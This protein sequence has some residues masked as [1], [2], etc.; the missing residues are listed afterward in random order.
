MWVTLIN[1]FTGVSQYMSE[2]EWQYNLSSMANSL[3]PLHGKKEVNPFVHVCSNHLTHIWSNRE[4]AITLFPA[5]KGYRISLLPNRMWVIPH[6]V[7]PRQS[8]YVLLND[9]LW[10][11]V[12]DSTIPQQGSH[13]DSFHDQQGVSDTAL[14]PCQAVS[15]TTSS[16]T[17]TPTECEWHS[18]ISLPGHLINPSWVWVTQL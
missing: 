6:S 10:Q 4:W 12:S 9:Q 15:S 7:C 2:C 14:F 13:H 3:W 17:V 16:P 18:L 5:E 11:W 1:F 8:C